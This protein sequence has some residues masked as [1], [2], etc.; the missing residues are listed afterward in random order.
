MTNETDPTGSTTAAGNA[1][2]DFLAMIWSN[3]SNTGTGLVATLKDE[4]DKV[5]RGF[6][7]DLKSANITAE[8][9]QKISWATNSLVAASAGV[10]IAPDDQIRGQLV[11]LRLDALAVLNAIEAVKAH[12]GEAVIKAQISRI[13]T[14]LVEFIET[15]LV[16][17]LAIAPLLA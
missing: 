5:A 15:G 14:F 8:E 17:G 2:L 12:Q 16:K 9:A 4:A 6:I 3:L 13:F 7:E 1:S 11:Q 10:L